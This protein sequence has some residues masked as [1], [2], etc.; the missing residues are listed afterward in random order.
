MAAKFLKS[1]VFTKVIFVVSLFLILFIAGLGY[2]HMTEV[3]ESQESV[4]HTYKVNVELEQI[5]SYLKDA[6][7]GQRGFIITQD[8][9]YLEPFFEG[10]GKI[11][12]T[13]AELK[14]LTKDD[15]EQTENLRLLNELIEERLEYFQIASTYALKDQTDLLRFKKVFFEGKMTMDAIRVK[16]NEM[17]LLENERLL[18]RKQA[19]E[20]ISN[21]TPLFLFGLIVFTLL[22]LY[23]SYA[24]IS[25]N[26]DKITASNKEL[27]VFKE[28]TN[29]SEMI[30]KHG[31]WRWNVN[32]DE[33][34]FSDNLF[35]LL[36][37]QPNSFAPT[38][39]NFMR[40]VHPEDVET[41]KDQVAQMK[42]D[43]DL[44]FIY[45]RVVH[46]NGTIRYLK[47][48]GKS[49]MDTEGNV[50]L[51]GTTTDITD[52]IDSFN[53]LQK[54]NKEL[55]LNNKELAAF[56]YV[57]S[58]DLQ[59]PLRKIQTF[60]SRL[61]DS[62]A[63]SLTEKG[64]TYMQRINVAASRM[65]L[66]IDDLLQY[67]RSSKSDE[68]KV[69][70]DLNELLQSALIELEEPIENNQAEIVA[71][72]LPELQVVPFQIQQ[73]FINLIGNALKYRK[74]ETAPVVRIQYSSVDKTDHPILSQSVAERFHKIDF[75]DNGIGFES[76]YGEKIFTLFTRLHNKDEYSGT[77]IG[78][79]IC[80]KITDNHRGHITA[81]ATPGSGAIFT[82]YLPE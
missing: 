5:L 66:L 46:K 32:T 4:M 30:N 67:S 36:G 56:N 3:S 6:E 1:A 33:F 13:F 47:A 65:R 80:R 21:I 12:N 45:Y 74:E 15:R 19:Y 43:M 52:E 17:I 49:I 71:D 18:K 44:P 62:E 16:L 26:L 55:E 78:L 35:R 69:P 29:Q 70:S 58:H 34:S 76:E 10:R 7:T 59:E 73:L 61:E 9:I 31:S 8:S 20:S 75:K 38:I 11:N 27:N 39:E 64:Q 57:A 51:L 23:L 40:F 82:I 81:T 72:P 14:Q 22:L 77:G 42:V 63:T 68:D 48:Y 28:L 2:K 41:L 54:R 24:R 37:E 60:L 25:V 79:A 50:Q 53:A